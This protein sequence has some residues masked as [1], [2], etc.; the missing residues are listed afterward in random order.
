MN[1]NKRG[2][3]LVGVLLAVVL[4]AVAAGGV[5]YYYATHAYPGP[6]GGID[7][8]FQSPI[9]GGASSTQS[10]TIGMPGTIASTTPNLFRAGNVSDANNQFAVNLYSRYAGEKGADE[11]VFFSPFSISSAIAMTYEGAK[12]QTAQEIG[13]VFHFPADISQVRN[14]YQ[15]AFAAINSNA[16]SYTLRVANALWVQKNYP[17]LDDYTNAIKTYYGGG[18]TNVDFVGNPTVAVSTINRWV[19]DKTAGKI[20]TILS[21]GDVNN[22]TRL[23][24]TNAIYFK[25]AWSDAFEKYAT[26]KKDFT[27]GGGGHV[28]ASMME[29][30]SHF[31]YAD[32]GTAQLLE[33]PY[34]GGDVSM[35]VILPKS[36]DLPAFEKGLTY[37]KISSWEKEAQSNLVDVS[38][39][40]FKIETAEHMPSDLKAMGM[41][42]AFS[43]TGADF[44]GIASIADPSQN[45]YIAD[46]IH[47][48]FIDTD[49]NGTEAA[50]ATAVV[51]APAASAFEPTPPKPVIFN[52]N[53]P[54]VFFLQENQTG[55]ILFMGR[56]VNPA[57][58]T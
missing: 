25:G 38:L 22:H 12:G 32:V 4:V 1:K 16:S 9:S 15:K 52:A 58:G 28:Q 10:S 51:M 46:V 41:L 44:S 29:Q 23:I 8:P 39:P 34:K 54:F 11:N 48:A 6:V 19:S 53:H 17:L 45:L 21:A 40:K 36:N 2:F 14:G 57:A 13:N 18:I 56:V 50:A 20:P 24:L 35:F 3:A 47:K 5:L 26:Q 37:S 7:P 55:N 30:T 33:L 27:T 31:A 42:A 49:E 43:P